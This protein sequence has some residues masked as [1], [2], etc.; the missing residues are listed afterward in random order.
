VLPLLMGRL[1]LM[2]RLRLMGNSHQHTPHNN[3]PTLGNRRNNQ[4]IP[5]H[6]PSQQHL[7]VFHHH[8]Q[9]N[10]LLQPHQEAM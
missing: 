2:D 10:T 7:G 4:R 3:N 8:P 5:I 9:P 6:T 1:R